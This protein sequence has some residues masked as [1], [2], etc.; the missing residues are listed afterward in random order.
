M[1]ET[2]RETKI[3]QIIQPSLSY[4]GTKQIINNFKEEMKQIK[5]GSYDRKSGESSWIRSHQF[6]MD[7]EEMLLLPSELLQDI[8]GCSPTSHFHIVIFRCVFYC[9]D[10]TTNQ[11]HLSRCM[12]LNDFE[13]DFEQLCTLKHEG[14]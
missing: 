12:K 5:Q 3:Q 14:K 2:K 9:E 7:Q 10:S 4:F 11:E 6:L 13:Q 8:T 1:K